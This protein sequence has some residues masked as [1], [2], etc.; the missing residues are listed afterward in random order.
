MVTDSDGLSDSEQT[1]DVITHSRG[2]LVLRTLIEQQNTLPAR[3]P[4]FQIGNAI[5]V[6][7]PNQGTPLA[8]P[9]RFEATIGLVANFLEM[10][11]DN[12]W[13]TGAEFVAHGITWLAKNLIGNL[14]GLAAQLKPFELAAA[15]SWRIAKRAGLE[16]CRCLI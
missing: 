15:W 12:P 10:F 9:D 14:P 8:T 6:A 3:A 5:L 13:T 4:R 7:A 11:P 2:G 16:E 1:F